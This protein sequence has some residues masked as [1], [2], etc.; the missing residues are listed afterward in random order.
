[1]GEGKSPRPVYET[2]AADS[3]T[4]PG[5]ATFTR[6]I[7]RWAGTALV[8]GALV[9]LLDFGKQQAGV[10][11][12]AG[13]VEHRCRDLGMAHDAGDNLEIDDYQRIR[14]CTWGGVPLA[15]FPA[16]DRKIKS[17]FPFKHLGEAT[18]AEYLS[19]EEVRTDNITRMGDSLGDLYDR[20]RTEVACLHIKCHDFSKLYVSDP[21]TVDFGNAVAPTFFH[22]L[23]RMMWED[24][25]LHLCRLTDARKG[26]LSLIR[27]AGAIPKSEPALRD[28]VN[29]L[30][31][32]AQGKTAFARDPRNRRIAHMEYLP[33][34]GGIAK[35]VVP[36]SWQNVEDALLAFQNVLNCIERFYLE[37]PVNFEGSIGVP[38][39]VESLIRHFKKTVTPVQLGFARRQRG[40]ASPP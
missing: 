21:A 19:A 33:A 31:T 22:N 15:S 20:L 8:H 3:E 28:E 27:L 11:A 32:A 29:V 6:V 36:A 2:R 35:V 30:A 24:I 39:G 38:G 26:T 5:E 14:G 16:A 40:N 7:D 1:M 12:H 10:V 9:D 17:R 4:G 18:M 37:A 23:Q 25:L 13:N 34:R